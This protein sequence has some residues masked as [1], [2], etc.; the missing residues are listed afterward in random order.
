MSNDKLQK[1]INSCLAIS[2]QPDISDWAKKFWKETAE[3][4][5]KKVDK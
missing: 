4:L 2:L 3:K 1:A 5:M